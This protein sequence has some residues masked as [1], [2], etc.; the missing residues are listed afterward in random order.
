MHDK[1]RTQAH[2]CNISCQEWTYATNVS[3]TMVFLMFKKFGI[4]NYT[5][6][7]GPTVQSNIALNTTLVEEQDQV[8]DMVVEQFMA[9]RGAGIVLIFCQSKSETKILALELQ[10][11][12]YHAGMPEEEHN[13]V[14]QGL[15]A[16]SIL[17]VACTSLLGVALDLGN[18]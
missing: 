9:E 12:C 15:K 8:M 14:M 13:L 5:I 7:C 4:I 17:A 11:D 10:I 1:Y 18:V 16:G 6:C 2:T 3:D